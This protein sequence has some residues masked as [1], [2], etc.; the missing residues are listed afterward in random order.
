MY[1][2]VLYVHAGIDMNTDKNNILFYIEQIFNK[3]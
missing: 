2:A 1:V 3:N